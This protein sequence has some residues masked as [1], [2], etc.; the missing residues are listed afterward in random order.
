[1]YKF[2]LLLQ[3]FWQVSCVLHMYKFTLLLQQFWQVSCVLHMCKFTLLLQQF[4]QVS[5][6]LHMYKF[7][8]L[9]Q[10]FWQV[11]FVLHMYKFTLL[12]QSNPQYK[13]EQLNMPLSDEGPPIPG[14][15]QETSHRLTYAHW[16]ALKFPV[17]MHGNVKHNQDWFLKIYPAQNYVC[18]HVRRSG[19]SVLCPRM[20]RRNVSA[21]GRFCIGETTCTKI[22]TTE[23]YSL[24]VQRCRSPST[25][26]PQQQDTV[27][28][29]YLSLT[30][31][32]MGKI[33]PETRWA[34]L[35]DQ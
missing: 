22:H 23:V 31:L 5:C 27:C 19:D 13:N 20:E 16:T 9:L 24:K 34:D 17:A 11:S 35:I 2:T 14:T 32:M 4:W 12:H 29:K 28:C 15:R 10:Q 33:L 8:L 30:L 1:M 6:V 25:Y 26:P 18:P 3:Q 7:T 21:E